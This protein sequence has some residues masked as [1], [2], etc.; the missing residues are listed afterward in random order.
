VK[1]AAYLKVLALLVPKEMKVEHSQNLKSM[2][3]EELD[4]AI[5][6]VR[7]ML[8]ERVAA[9]GA[10]IEGTAETFALPAPAELEPPKRKRSNRLLEHADAAVVP[11]ERKPRKRVPW[12]ASA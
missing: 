11:K 9:G 2:S 10:V 3:D 4:A 5:A 12:P 6:A 1:P 8:D 7:E